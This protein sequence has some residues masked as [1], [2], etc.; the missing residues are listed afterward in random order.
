MYYKEGFL[1]RGSL[2]TTKSESLHAYYRDQSILPTFAA[3]QTRNELQAFADKRELMFLEN[4]QIPS[5]LFQNAR[6]LEV[7]PDSGENA[8]VFA[9][10]GSRL[11]LVE[12]NARAW[13]VI[14]NYLDH[15]KLGDCIEHFAKMSLEEFSSRNKFDFIVAEGFIFTIRP[16]HRWI[17]SFKKLSKPGGYLI[18]TQSESSGMLFDLLWRAVHVRIKRL[19]GLNSSEAAR[20]LFLKKWNSIPHT[21]SFE[22]WVMDMLNNPFARLKY[23]YDARW[24][25]TFLERNGFSMYSSWPCYQDALSMSWHKRRIDRWEKISRNLA[26]LSRSRLSFALGCKSFVRTDSTAKVREINHWIDVLVSSI[27]GLIKSFN[28]PAV[29]KALIHAER[30]ADFVRKGGTLEEDQTA[31]VSSGEVLSGLLS[32]LKAMRGEDAN[33]IIEICNNNKALL[34]SW[35]VPHHL[36]V[37]RR[38]VVR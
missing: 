1:K 14:Q 13:G 22:S 17:N 29:A 8:L 16:E 23:C 33:R 25:Y 9:Q 4:L 26:Y 38:D 31:L 35:G 28:R 11:T 37:F 21:R 27:D 2:K 34:H 5:R 24:F 36:Y 32:L 6:V 20:L 15:F 30:L 18:L 10:W 19:T 12:P 3:L 7:G